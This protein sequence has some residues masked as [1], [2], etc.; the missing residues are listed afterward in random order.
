GGETIEIAENLGQRVGGDS[1][2]AVGKSLTIQI[3]KDLSKNIGGSSSESVAK[4]HSMTAKTITL[5][6]QQQL[7][8]KAGPAQIVLMESGDIAITGTN[9]MVNGDLLVSI[10]GA[11]VSVG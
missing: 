6:A 3:D 9:I 11:A 2:F 7:V 8:L 4:D 1:N 5:Q 10:S